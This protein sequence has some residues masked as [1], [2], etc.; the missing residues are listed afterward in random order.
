ME[1]E[2]GTQVYTYFDHFSLFEYVN[3][4]LNFTMT[5]QSIEIYAPK[6]YSIRKVPLQYYKDSVTNLYSAIGVLLGIEGKL[7]FKIIKSRYSDYD[8]DYFV[9]YIDL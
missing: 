4:E 6:H 2:D 8:F 3:Y 5:M 9:F 7:S 1:E